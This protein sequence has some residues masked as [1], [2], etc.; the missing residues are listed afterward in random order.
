MTC[1]E[2]ETVSCKGLI[3]NKE[4]DVRELFCGSK[5]QNLL[6]PSRVQIFKII[7]W[8]QVDYLDM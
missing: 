8:D 5:I 7:V 6:F 2:D 3:P 4:L 1:G